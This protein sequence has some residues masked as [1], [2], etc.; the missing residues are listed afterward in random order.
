MRKVASPVK[1]VN[2]AIIEHMK[3][4]GTS[5]PA[6]ILAFD[7][8][9]QTAQIQIAIV[10]ID[11]DGNEYNLPPVIEC[12]VYFAGGSDF[13]VEH[14]VNPQDECL[15]VF[16]QRCIDGWLNTGGI[17]QQPIV[18]FHDINDAC[19]FV[20]IRSEPN[21]IQNHA[22]DGIR[23]RNKSGSDYI[24]LKKD[25]SIDIKSTANVTINGVT[26]TPSGAV[27]MPQ[28]LDVSGAV[29]GGSGKFD[30]VTVETHTH[31]GV[32]AGGASTGEPN[33]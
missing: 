24:W 2:S 16:S 19:V 11:I 10:R 20:G 6:H 9:N 17:A 14:E 7:P 12:P 22:N 29:T 15:A 8:Q 33:K 18:R 30:G 5:I 25:G 32:L 21:A 27:Q 1:F 31:G 28:T 3:D 23:L 26:I 13:F 4:V